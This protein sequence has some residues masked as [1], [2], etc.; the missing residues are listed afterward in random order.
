MVKLLCVSIG[1]IATKLSLSALL[2]K[3]QQR[4]PPPHT[5]ALTY[6]TLEKPS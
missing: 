4:A 5:E 6:N 2:T 1:A 3:Q